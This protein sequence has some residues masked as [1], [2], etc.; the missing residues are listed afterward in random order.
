[1]T[2]R[3]RAIFLTSVTT[4]AGMTPL[5]FETSTPALILVPLV[6]SIVFGML[7]STVLIMLVLPAMYGFKETEHAPS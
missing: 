4:I 3:F 7:T 1:V 5:P 2:D 6:T